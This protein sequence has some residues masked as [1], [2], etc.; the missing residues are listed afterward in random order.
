[1][2][3]RWAAAGLCGVGLLLAAVFLVSAPRTHSE[4]LAQSAVPVG[5]WDHVDGL[6]QR[7]D[8]A[9]LSAR[10]ST[11]RY[12]APPAMGVHCFQ[13]TTRSRLQPLA[14]I[15]AHLDALRTQQQAT[16]APSL[17]PFQSTTSLVCNRTLAKHWFT[18]HNTSTGDLA[19][20]RIV[21]HRLRSNWNQ[22]AWRALSRLIYVCN[23]LGF[24]PMLHGRTL[25]SWFRQCDFTHHVD[26]L[27]ITLDFRSL[28]SEEAFYLLEARFCSPFPL[29]YDLCL[30]LSAFGSGAALSAC[31]SLKCRT[32]LCCMAFLLLCTCLGDLAKLFSRSKSPTCPL[33][34][35]VSLRKSLR[36]PVSPCSLSLF[37]LKTRW[38]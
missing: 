13:P 22:M 33:K 31:D 9:W 3:W 19:F 23:S 21:A 18:A 27:S 4:H 5:K 30:C 17:F 28:F 1:M 38:L 24:H 25:L 35:R 16:G 7:D 26:H 11:S 15:I 12:C 2:W 10:P 14:V 8:V 36:W 6:A 20:D 34:T 37:D 29:S 32:R